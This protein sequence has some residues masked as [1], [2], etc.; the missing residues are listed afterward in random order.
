MLSRE[1]FKVYS[2]GAT[3]TSPEFE[4]KCLKEL[5]NGKNITIPPRSTVIICNEK[6]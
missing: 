6:K 5:I 1:H 2:Y 4:E 3:R